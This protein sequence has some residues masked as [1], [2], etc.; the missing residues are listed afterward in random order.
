MLS[1]YANMLERLFTVLVARG[2]WVM[3]EASDCKGRC[4]LEQVWSFFCTLEQVI[5]PQGIWTFL[6]LPSSS[7]IFG[8]FQACSC[9]ST[10]S[11]HRRNVS[12][13]ASPVILVFQGFH[14]AVYQVRYSDFEERLLT[15]CPTSRSSWRADTWSRCSSFSSD[16]LYRSS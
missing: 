13:M 10:S 4:T 1:K 7:S 5:L 6:S 15:S 14:H 9:Q 2:A 16:P 8:V 3:V 12:T 11:V